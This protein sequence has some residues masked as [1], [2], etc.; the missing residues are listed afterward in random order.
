MALRRWTRAG[1]LA[2]VGGLL[3]SLTMLL[4]A[5]SPAAAGTAGEYDLLARI[6]KARIANGLPAVYLSRWES[7]KVSRPWTAKMASAW[8]LS[9]NPSYASQTTQQVTSS[10]TRITENVGYGPN[11]ATTFSAF[12]NSAPHRANILDSRVNWVGLGVVVQGGRT[13]ITMNFVKTSAS[14]GLDASPFGAL[15]VSRS[16]DQITVK[17]WSIDPSVT[18]PIQIQVIVD[19]AWTTIRADD[20]RSDV[21]TV[22]PAFTGYHGYSH[23][24]PGGDA[25]RTVCVKALNTWAGSNVTLGCATV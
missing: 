24:L 22:F 23:S 19:G 13:W 18:S 17:G 3:A 11:M 16:G 25:P 1:V 20:Y 2:T 12:M 9:H 14:I 8:K 4:P 5:A 7:D 6:N 10:W 15:S 21:A